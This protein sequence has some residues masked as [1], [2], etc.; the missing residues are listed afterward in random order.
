ML[1]KT[2]VCS[3]WREIKA[4]KMFMLLCFLEMVLLERGIHQRPEFGFRSVILIQIG[5]L[6][7]TYFFR[8]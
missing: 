6:S 4:Y 2:T 5:R 1:C 3:S 7:L 8:T